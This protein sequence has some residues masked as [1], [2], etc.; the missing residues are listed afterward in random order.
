MPPKRKP[1]RRYFCSLVP[2]LE[3]RDRN[4]R[5]NRSSNEYLRSTYNSAL[6]PFNF[7]GR[8]ELEPPDETSYYILLYTCYIIH[9]IFVIYTSHVFCLCKSGIL[10]RNPCSSYRC[11]FR[12]ALEAAGRN[13]EAG[14][15]RGAWR[16]WMVKRWLWKATTYEGVP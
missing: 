8:V 13:V 4:P 6:E 3:G 1:W 16:W 9:F 12:A 14:A 5:M 11:P 7:L 2:I 15:Q 10:H